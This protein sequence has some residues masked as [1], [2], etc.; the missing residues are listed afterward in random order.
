MAVRG[1]GGA[2]APSWRPFRPHVNA[3][4]P[5]AAHND[6]AVRARAAC[7]TEDELARAVTAERDDWE[8]GALLVLEEELALRGTLGPY[9][10]PPQIAPPASPPP[11]TRWWH[12][13]VAMLAAGSVI[14]VGLSLAV[15]GLSGHLL[16]RVV[17]ACFIVS[18]AL[19]LRASQ[20]RSAE[21]SAPAP[22]Q[23]S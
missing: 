20:R 18:I 15:H 7:M 22:E 14:N 5:V 4:F 17:W 1:L 16:L 6:Q 23:R 10:E 19:R 21:A 9:R 3:L 13:W 12:I 11:K 2:D 8:P